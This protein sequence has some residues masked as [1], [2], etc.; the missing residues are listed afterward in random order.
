MKKLLAAMLRPQPSERLTNWSLLVFR[1]VLSV[2]MIY[3][4]GLKK[5][6]EAPHE[7]PN[8][9]QMPPALVYALALGSSVFFPLLVAAGVFTRFSAAA[10]LI[11]TLTG[12]FVVHGSDPAA[13]RDVPFM[14]SLAFMLV[15]VLG[16][17][18]FSADAW[19]HN[20]LK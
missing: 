18:R 11:T 9:F 7:V 8:P 3:V 4:H 2:Q 13:V 19:L 12:Y 6:D 10:V 20:K 17:G 16:P 15:L 5:F 14:Y 1:V